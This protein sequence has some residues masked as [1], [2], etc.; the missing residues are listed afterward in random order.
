MSNNHQQLTHQ[1]TTNSQLVIK[2]PSMIKNKKQDILVPTLL[3]VP[4]NKSTKKDN[5]TKNQ[6]KNP[7]VNNINDSTLS[8]VALPCTNIPNYTNHTQNTTTPPT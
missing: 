7:I 3:Y 4:T 1:L 8:T 6:L 5:Y 2:T